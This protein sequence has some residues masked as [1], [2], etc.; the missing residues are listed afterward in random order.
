MT[1]VVVVLG[2]VVSLGVGLLLYWGVR[3]EAGQ[4]EQMSRADAE[5]AA[6]RDTDD[7]GR[8]GKR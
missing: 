5:R 2:L 4:R 6:R 8:D 1:V 3:A 7:P